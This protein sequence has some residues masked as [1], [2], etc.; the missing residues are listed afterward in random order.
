GIVVNTFRELEVAAVK[1]VEDGDCFPDRK[2]TPPS[3]YCIGPLIADA[4]QPGQLTCLI[5]Y[6]NFC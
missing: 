5:K 3:I 1:A 2:R 4:Q 6:I